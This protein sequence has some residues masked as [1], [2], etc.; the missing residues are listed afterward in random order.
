MWLIR[1]YIRCLGYELFNRPEN[2]LAETPE[3]QPV[4][5]P[6]DQLADRPEDQPVEQ[7]G[8]TDRGTK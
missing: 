7:P 4:E 6:G 5:Q 1:N 8:Q 2:Q 3:D